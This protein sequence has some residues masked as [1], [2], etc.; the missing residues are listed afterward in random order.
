[1]TKLTL[2][3]PSVPFLGSSSSNAWWSGRKSGNDG[4]PPYNIE[5]TSEPSY[6]ITLAVRASR[7]GPVD[8]GGGSAAS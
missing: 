8:H 6:R 1:M 5:Q 7:G 3:D 2:G 4:Y